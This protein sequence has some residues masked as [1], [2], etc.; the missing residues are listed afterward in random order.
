MKQ[1]VNYKV[2]VDGNDIFDCK[3]LDNKSEKIESFDLQV[4]IEQFKKIRQV[5]SNEK[6][7]SQDSQCLLDIYKFELQ[8]EVTQKD[9]SD[10]KNLELMQFSTT[11][12]Q[13]SAKSLLVMNGGAVVVL[14]AYMGNISKDIKGIQLFM[15]ALSIMFFVVGLTFICE[16]LRDLMYLTP[17]HSKFIENQV[18][19]FRMQYKKLN[20]NFKKSFKTFEYGFILG[21]VSIVIPQFLKICLIFIKI[22]VVNLK[23]LMQ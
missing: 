11:T 8:R 21:L 16:V 15:A 1:E 19:N 2:V 4:H 3:V 14:L 6:L 10:K 23:I 9:F 5:S 12:L 18:S 17:N 22:I 20:K 13:N 7:N